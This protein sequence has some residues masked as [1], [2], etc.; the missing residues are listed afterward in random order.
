[1]L[2][3]GYFIPFW[4]NIPSLN[5]LFSSKAALTL[6]YLSCSALKPRHLPE[7]A[8]QGAKRAK[9]PVNTNNF[10]KYK[11]FMPPPFSV[12]HHLCITRTEITPFPDSSGSR[13]FPITVPI[14]SRLFISAFIACPGVSELVSRSPL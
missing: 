1:M 5:A 3:G 6:G 12:P 8:G 10:F 7:S 11:L 13:A 2:S 9:R 14:L 4:L